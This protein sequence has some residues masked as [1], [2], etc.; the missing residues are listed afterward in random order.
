MGANPGSPGVCC[1]ALSF[2]DFTPYPPVDSLLESPM[3][4]NL[5]KPAAF[6]WVQGIYSCRFCSFILSELPVTTGNTPIYY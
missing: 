2:C 4:S 3:I 5:E 1:P 6:N